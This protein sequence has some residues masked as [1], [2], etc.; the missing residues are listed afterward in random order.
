MS[1]ACVLLV[2]LAGCQAE[3]LVG[4]GSACANTCDTD[5]QCVQGV[6]TPRDE[7][8]A[9]DSALPEHSGE[10]HSDEEHSDEE[11]SDESQDSDDDDGL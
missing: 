9:G 4:E 2:L 6:C 7:G 5:E 3:G 10:E 8:A 11:Q 1:R